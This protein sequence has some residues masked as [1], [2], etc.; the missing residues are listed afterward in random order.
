VRSYADDGEWGIVTEVAAVRAID[1][2]QVRDWLES[3]GYDSFS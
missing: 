3:E 1:L 2:A